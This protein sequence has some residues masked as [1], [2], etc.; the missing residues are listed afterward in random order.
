MIIATKE[1]DIQK[2]MNIYSDRD[3]LNSYVE[4]L[5]PEK[6]KHLSSIYSNQK[7]YINFKILENKEISM[8]DKIDVS[9]A[10]VEDLHV[11]GFTDSY[12]PIDE[13]ERFINHKQVSKYNERNKI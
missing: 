1:I 12:I 3:T 2:V 7:F 13:V 10:L 6:Y 4:S 9:R 5:I 8:N 11:V